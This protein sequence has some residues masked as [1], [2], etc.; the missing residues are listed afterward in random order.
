MARVM[1]VNFGFLLLVMICFGFLSN[2][3]G[4]Q[5]DDDGDD[6]TAVYIVTL[7]QPPFVHLFEEEDLKQIRHRHQSPKHGHTSKFKPKLQP[8]YRKK[9]FFFILSL[10]S[11]YVA[12]VKP[13]FY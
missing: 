7:K 10:D 11:L 9:Y 2:T 8:R 13:S 5:Q 1:L 4:Q 3:L 6:D 12:L